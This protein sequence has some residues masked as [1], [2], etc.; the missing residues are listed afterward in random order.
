MAEFDTGVKNYIMGECIVKVHFPVDFRDSADINCYQCKFFSRASGI[1]R[2][3]NEVSEYPQKY[4]GSQCPL[5]FS[6]EIQNI[7][8]QKGGSRK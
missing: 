7:N 6:G 4:I 1:C 5:E 8:E 2:L 3:T